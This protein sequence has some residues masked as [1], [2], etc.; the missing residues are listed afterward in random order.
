MFFHAVSLASAFGVSYSIVIKDPKLSAIQRELLVV[1][2]MGPS[3]R[4]LT[5][6]Q[7]KAFAL[8]TEFYKIQVLLL[9]TRSG[10]A[11]YFI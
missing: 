5:P 6:Q 7:A 1:A 2:K 10:L 11:L 4:S 3:L 8:A 9:D